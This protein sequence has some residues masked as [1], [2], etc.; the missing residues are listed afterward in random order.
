MKD[1]KCKGIIE[2]F[3]RVTGFF[4]PIKQWNKGKRQEFVDRK[5]FDLSTIKSIDKD[6][7]NVVK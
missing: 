7:T 6:D 1:N 5:K 3:S 2:V 4:T